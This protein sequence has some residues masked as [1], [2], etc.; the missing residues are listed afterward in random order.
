[1]SATECQVGAAAPPSMHWCYLLNLTSGP[2]AATG[3]D[4][5]RGF[6]PPVPLAQRMW[7]GGKTEFIEPLRVGDQVTRRSEIAGV[8]L[9][10]GR[11]G[12]LCFVTI[13]HTYSTARGVATKD[14]QNLVFLNPAPQPTV[15]PAP[16]PRPP[17]RR[18]QHSSVMHADAAMLFRYSA[19]THNG[20]PSHYDRPYATDIEK[21]PGLMVHGPLQA[22]ILLEYAIQ[23]HGA[24]PPKNFR[25]RGVATM[26]EGEFT[27]NA[28]PVVNGIELWTA[29]PAGTPC[30]TA[31]ATW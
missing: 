23:L 20:H 15:K 28:N 29:D 9:K 3:T 2:G 4:D 14:T 11:S 19:L 10:Y 1:M 27:V 26:F 7:A 30:M 17:A 6:V 25:H 24:E 31:E 21:S 16:T 22:A 12:P 8:E 13:Q 5:E 18:T